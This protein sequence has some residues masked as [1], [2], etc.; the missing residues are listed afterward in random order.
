MDSLVTT[1]ALSGGPVSPRTFVDETSR[2]YERGKFSGRE[3]RTGSPGKLDKRE[4]SR[5]KSN[6]ERA[7]KGT[8]GS[9]R[10]RGKS[11]CS[12][13]NEFSKETPKAVSV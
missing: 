8:F 11:R 13:A 10:R 12:F 9:P 4:E 7:W 6:K 3:P 5:W 2:W 1:S